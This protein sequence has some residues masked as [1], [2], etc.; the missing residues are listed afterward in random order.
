M[1]PRPNL[2]GWMRTDRIVIR[3]A[4]ALERRLAGMDR[5]ANHCISSGACS[6]CLIWRD[7]SLLTK[8]NTG[9]RALWPWWPWWPHSI[10]SFRGHGTVCAGH[11][12]LTT[13]RCVPSLS[14]SL[15]SHRNISIHFGDHLHQAQSESRY[16]SRCP[17]IY[18]IA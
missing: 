10:E 6:K 9:E 1:R 15:D 8:Q 16:T 18:R 11:E 17:C 12:V 7:L 2:L 13:S 3:I 5:Q 14:V 4:S